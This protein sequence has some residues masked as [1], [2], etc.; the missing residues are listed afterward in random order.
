[1]TL[2]P[3][4]KNYCATRKELLAMVKVDKHFLTVPTW[5]AFQSMSRQCF[6]QMVESKERTIKPSPQ[7]VR[8]I[9]QVQIHSR[10]TELV[11]S[12]E[13]PRGSADEVVVTAY[14]VT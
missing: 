14:I 11:S 6:I 9:S 10:S 13:V 7:V 8:N 5:T 4:E 3:P 12:M 2:A 1:M